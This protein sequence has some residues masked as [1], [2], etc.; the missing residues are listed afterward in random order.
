[1][2]PNLADNN[3]SYIDAKQLGPS[4]L[5]RK[6]SAMKDSDNITHWL[7]NFIGGKGVKIIKVDT[8]VFQ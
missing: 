3:N 6:I 2:D 7:G 5:E 8:D 1:M 4:K